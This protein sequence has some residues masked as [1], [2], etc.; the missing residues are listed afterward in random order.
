MGGGIA[1]LLAAHHPDRVAT[2]TLVATSPA[3]ERADRTRLPPMDPALAQGPPEPDWSDPEAV[4]TYLVE[5]ERPYAGAFFD[6]ERARRTARR[7]VGRSH[8]VAAAA[9]HWQLSGDAEPFAMAAIRVPTLVLH[10]TDDRL[11]QLPHGEALAAEIAGAR[12]IVLP[13]M[14]HEAP[15]PQTWDVVVPAL[16]AHT[17]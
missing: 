3:G 12:L 4:V 14:G 17:A 8:D 1:Q 7:V 10:G 13:G 9:N 2:L 15:P 6:P 5:L 16:L 11:F